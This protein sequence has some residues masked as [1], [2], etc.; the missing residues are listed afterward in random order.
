MGHTG[1]GAIFGQR[2]LSM[3]VVKCDG[4]HRIGQV[5]WQDSSVVTLRRPGPSQRCG[6][7]RHFANFGKVTYN[8]RFGRPRGVL[9]G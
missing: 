1:V 6:H 4:G 7:Q 2:E 3:L 8:D 9:V 5:E